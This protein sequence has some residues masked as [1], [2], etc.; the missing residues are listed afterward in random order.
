[1]AFNSIDWTIDFTGRTVTND[2]SVIGDNL[3]TNTGGTWFVG[4]IL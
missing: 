4:E 3:P 1:M 2:D